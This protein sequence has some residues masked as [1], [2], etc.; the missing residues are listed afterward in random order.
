MLSYLFGYSCVSFMQTSSTDT[1]SIQDGI[2]FDSV[3]ESILAVTYPIIRNG[4][5][6]IDVPSDIKGL[7]LQEVNFVVP[8][9]GE[10]VNYEAPL[11]S[12]YPSEVHNLPSSVYKEACYNA[13]ISIFDINI[14]SV[15]LEYMSSFVATYCRELLKNQIQNLKY[16]ATDMLYYPTEP[17]ENVY[18]F[19][20]ADFRNAEYIAGFSSGMQILYSGAEFNRINLYEGTKIDDYAF[21]GVKCEELHI[22]GDIISDNRIFNN[23]VDGPWYSDAVE[24]HSTTDIIFHEGVTKIPEMMFHGL[25]YY[26]DGDCHTDINSLSFPSSL[27]EIGRGAFANSDFHENALIIPEGVKKIGSSAF[28]AA[29]GGSIFIPSGVEEIGEDAIDLS[30]GSIYTDAEEAPSGWINAFGD[31]TVVYYGYTLEEYAAEVGITI[32]EGFT[33]GTLVSNT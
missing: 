5:I 16:I 15:E 27:Q 33:G 7:F 31:R 2:L 18:D 6:Y 1:I 30:G 29:K 9:A 8:V 24:M 28:L 10:L 20:I 26:A 22:Y 3:S 4:K 32:P 21:N 12:E 17:D 13:L 23:C 14:P 19:G 11:A 25:P